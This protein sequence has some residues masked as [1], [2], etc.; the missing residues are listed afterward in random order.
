MLY[1]YLK[2][3][4]EQAVA[5]LLSHLSVV[6]EVGEAFEIGGGI[7]FHDMV[8]RYS[9]LHEDNFARKMATSTKVTAEP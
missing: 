2:L 8:N 4:P 6:A 1:V 7:T 5:L 3:G 9:D